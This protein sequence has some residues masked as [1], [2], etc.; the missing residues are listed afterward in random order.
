MKTTT[1]IVILLALSLGLFTDASAIGRVYARLPNISNGTVYNLRIKSLTATVT[2]HDQLAVTSV[3]QEFANDNSIRLE[4]FYVFQLPAGAQVHEMYLWINGVRVPYTI[5][6]REDAIVKYTEIVSRIADPAILEDLGGNQF[7]LRVFPFDAKGTRRVEILYSQPLTYYKGKIQY[8]FPLDMKD[9]TS[10]PIETASL[11]IR[12]DSQFP[13]TAVET[14]V[15][16]FPAAVKVTKLTDRSYTIA[17]GVEKVAFAKDFVATISLNRGTTSMFALPYAAPD[18]LHEDP[19]F[20]LWT[21]LPDTL[22][23]DSIKTRELTFVADISSSMEGSRIASLKESLNSFVDLLTES[24]KFNII[25]FS[26]STVKFRENL[27]KATPAARDSARLFITKLAALGVTNIEEA[28][29]ASLAQ[30]YTDNLRSAIILV[31]DGQATFGDTTTA[32]LLAT[33][34][35]LN[36]KHIRMFPIGIGQEPNVTLLQLLAKQQSGFF[37]PI[38]SDDSIYAKMKDVY[39]LLFLPQV[40]SIAVSFGAATVSDMHPTPIPDVYAGDQLRLTGRFTK[41][42]ISPVTLTGIAGLTPVTLQEQV[43]LMTDTSRSFSAV[44]RYW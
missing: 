26:T 17:Y 12:F 43:Y 6:K 16:Q 30:S 38:A 14:S 31:T 20:I 3:D 23:K 40:K 44:A 19:Y 37:T 11:S 32:S 7:R 24:D 4:G 27:V 15:D 1:F 28:L 33:T 18:S 41:S 21:A 5:K 22:V 29:R 35:L 39:R 34:T 25:A 13:V 2:I 10:L 8:T 9:Y 42:V 36:T